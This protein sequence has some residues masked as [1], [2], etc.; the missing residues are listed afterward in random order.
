MMKQHRLFTGI[1]I[2][3]TAVSIALTM[4]LF[5]VFYI[6]LGNIYP[7]YK[8]DRML[9]I[10]EETHRKDNEKYGDIGHFDIDFVEMLKRETKHL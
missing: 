5:I 6:T 10:S 7:E 4:V 2:T 8:R 1:Y 9:I 3:G